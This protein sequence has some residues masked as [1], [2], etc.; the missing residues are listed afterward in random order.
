M[1]LGRYVRVRDFMCIYLCVHVFLDTC[2]SLSLSLCVCVC[3]W[4]CVC[5]YVCMCMCECVCVCEC[6]CECVHVCVI[7]VTAVE[8]I[9]ICYFII[10]YNH[11]D[12]DA[13][14]RIYTDMAK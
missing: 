1:C 14:K 4:V 10:L 12:L 5:V 7:I 11:M 2:F 6:V 8:P 9:C 13:Y 3:V